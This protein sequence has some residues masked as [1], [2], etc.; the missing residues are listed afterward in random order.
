MCVKSIILGIVLFSFADST[1]QPDRERASSE[2]TGKLYSEIKKLYDAN[3]PQTIVWIEN[4]TGEAIREVGMTC[5]SDGQ[6][7]WYG[8][9]FTQKTTIERELKEIWSEKY[10]D[11]IVL[12]VLRVRFDKGA[13]CEFNLKHRCEPGAKVTLIIDVGG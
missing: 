4:R 6:W 11:S 10:P 7:R 13:W 5:S 8:K 2:S 9:N 3:P 12:R 1:S